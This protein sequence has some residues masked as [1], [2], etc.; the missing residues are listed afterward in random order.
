MINVE[1]K[2]M[3]CPRCMGKGFVDLDDIRRLGKKLEW[4]QGYCRYC[5]A[6]GFVERG[7]PKLFDPRKLDTGSNFHG[8][9]WHSS[10]NI[11]ILI[12]IPPNFLNHHNSI[13][14]NQPTCQCTNI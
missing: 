8:W 4:G 3:I 5:D 12:Q 10:L 6:Q 2:E 14:K 13:I 1:K 9:L 11:I 7:K